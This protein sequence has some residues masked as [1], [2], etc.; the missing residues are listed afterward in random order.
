MIKTENFT[1]I[2][3]DKENQKLC[4]LADELIENSK[5]K[6]VKQVEERIKLSKPDKILGNALAIFA[7][8][9]GIGYL[10]ISPKPKDYVFIDLLLTKDARGKK[11]G[12]HIT[13]E[14]E[15]YLFATYS[16]LKEIRLDIDNSN[17]ASQKVA[18]ENGYFTDDEDFD[19]LTN[20]SSL[21]YKKANPYY[22]HPKK[23]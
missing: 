20:P 19:Y 16:D 6:F 9:N 18:E 17:L 5:S 21:I 8:E 23:R 14:I 2:P 10:F 15:E 22:I 1:F 7:G 11:Y 3:F 4:L 13:S 12:R